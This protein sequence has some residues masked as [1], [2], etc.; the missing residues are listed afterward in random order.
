MTCRFEGEK[1]HEDDVEKE[2][3][4]RVNKDNPNRPSCYTVKIGDIIVDPY[5]IAIEYNLD[6]VIFQAV[7]KLLRG[8]RTDKSLQQDVAEAIDTLRRWQEITK[9]KGR[10]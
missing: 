1:Q 4:C 9:E 6:P 10:G 8:G 5:R 7:K 2:R 3:R